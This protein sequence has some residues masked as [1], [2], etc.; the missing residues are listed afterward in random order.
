MP[1]NNRFVDLKRSIEEIEHHLEAAPERILAYYDEDTPPLDKYPKL[2]RPP[3]QFL[4]EDAA[5]LI[6]YE[7]S[8]QEKVEVIIFDGNDAKH[9]VQ[10][11]N[12]AIATEILLNGFVLD[13]EPDWYVEKMKDRETPS[14]GQ[15]KRKICAD[16]NLADDQMK[17]ISLVL[18]L[19]QLQRNNAVHAG[20]HK[21]SHY[22]HT[23]P[24]YEV[25][26]FLFS[27]ISEDNLEVVE[28]LGAAA[29][30]IREKQ[31]MN[32]TKPVNFPIE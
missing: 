20:F 30:E 25:L 19:L 27:Y 31:T 11:T 3:A 18:D 15:C 22:A 13:H 10:Y 21:Q 1:N 5:D 17:R 4:V 24:I 7:L 26:Q 6:E 16:L 9:R 29:T 23:A 32:S 14:I 28:R 2:D 12:L 8:R